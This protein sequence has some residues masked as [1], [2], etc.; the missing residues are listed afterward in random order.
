L[1]HSGMKQEE[2]R[3]FLEFCFEL[4]EGRKHWR[5][6]VIPFSAKREMGNET[7]DMWHEKQNSLARKAISNKQYAMNSN[8]N[9]NREW[10]REFRDLKLAF[11]KRIMISGRRVGRVDEPRT[12]GVSLFLRTTTI[13]SSIGIEFNWAVFCERVGKPGWNDDRVM[14]RLHYEI[15]V[16]KFELY[17]HDTLSITQQNKSHNTA[18]PA[19]SY[20]IYHQ[21]ERISI[22]LKTQVRQFNWTLIIQSHEIDRIAQDCDEIEIMRGFEAIM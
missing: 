2:W 11:G 8:S 17:D 18:S 19:L 16:P 20:G 15:V 21:Q 13:W 12:F 10:R 4:I 1:L 9:E 14:L 3:E 7:C 22:T 6:R 5:L